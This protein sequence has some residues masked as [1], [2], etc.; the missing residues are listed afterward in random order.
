M[1]ATLL[2]IVLAGLAS[3]LI[4]AGTRPLIPSL[5]GEIAAGAV[6]GRTGLGVIDPSRLAA[7]LSTA[8]PAADL[9]DGGSLEHGG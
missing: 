1:F 3:P 8:S 4:A 2:V 9:P 6:L 5:V 7:S